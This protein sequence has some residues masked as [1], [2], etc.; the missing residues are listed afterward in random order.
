[1]YIENG[2]HTRAHHI[3]R[4]DWDKCSRATGLIDKNSCD[5][6]F[7]FHPRSRRAH[8]LTVGSQDTLLVAAA[9]TAAVVL[10]IPFIIIIASVCIKF[11]FLSEHFDFTCESRTAFHL[12]GYKYGYLDMEGSALCLWS[13]R[14]A[15]RLSAV[16]VRTVC[17]SQA[18]RRWWRRWLRRSLSDRNSERKKNVQII[19]PTAIPFPK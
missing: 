9:A 15:K 16:N 12:L 3:T 19:I 1:M 11:D 13:L 7:H 8:T 2:T 10:P 14:S 6:H 17:K 4:L 5:F 18:Q